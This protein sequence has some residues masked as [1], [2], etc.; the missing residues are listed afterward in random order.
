MECP[1]RLLQYFRT[2]GF[3]DAGSGAVG[4]SANVTQVFQPSGRFCAA[5]SQ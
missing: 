1:E 3:A 4:E 5:N 2:I